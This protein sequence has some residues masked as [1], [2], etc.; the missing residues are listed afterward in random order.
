VLFFRSK[1]PEAHL[2]D[3][4][5]IDRQ[6][7]Q[8][9][10]LARNVETEDAHRAACQQWILDGEMVVFHEYRDNEW[11]IVTVEVKSGT[12]REFARGRQV[13]FCQPNSDLVPLYGPHG[14]PGDH[15]H[16]ELLNVRSGA[17]TKA[18]SIDSVRP[19]W[20]NTGAT[21]KYL[22]SQFGDKPISI[23]FPMMSPDGN[24]VF[25]KLATPGQSR[26]FRSH[27]YS[28]RKGVFFYDLKAKGYL[29]FHAKWGHPAWSADSRR[30]INM[31]SGGPV[32]LNI[33]EP[34]VEEQLAMPDYM[35]SGGHPAMSPDGRLLVTDGQMSA[36]K[37]RWGVAVGSFGDSEWQL[38]KEFDNSHGATSWRK[39]H[40]HPVFNR[41]GKRTYFNVNSDRWT[42]LYVAELRLP[43]SENGL[44]TELSADDR[45][46]VLLI[47]CDDLG[48]SDLGCYCGEIQTPHL[49]RLA[50]DGMR[51]TQ[52]YNCA[53]C[54]TTRSALLTGLYPRQS[55]RPRLRTNMITLG[56]A[57]RQAGYATSLTGK[58][59][60]GSE[61]PLRPIDRGFN[62]YYGVLDG[63]CNFSTRRNRIQ[64][65]TTA[66]GSVRLHITTNRSRS[67]P[68]AI[69]QRMPFRT[70]RSKL[71]SALPKATSRSSYISATPRRTF[72]CMHLLKTSSG[73]TE[74]TRT[75]ITR[76]GSGD[77]S[78]RPNWG[79]LL[80]C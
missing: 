51:F 15:P 62:E 58:W 71:L 63:C 3:V 65:S 26:D 19:V 6:T 27:A 4:C 9:R 77:I 36:D 41:D 47:L 40:P 45:P 11:R 70:T 16:L 32:L 17:I 52:F 21:G 50:A 20:A 73:T 28:L 24:R 79:C 12:R 69:T 42:R 43:K 80:R 44:S 34:T 14:N 64:C 39:N 78:G 10:V 49:D 56:E 61:L 37:R 13:G 74:S 30:I 48:Y 46:N 75:V 57:M 35:K 29:Y 8:V 22:D 23:C 68:K 31:W 60:L 5:I 25:F 76:C 1:T 59:H 33:E 66:V 18:V 38:L 54:V 67:F 2:G 55:K 7:N 53:V 72:R